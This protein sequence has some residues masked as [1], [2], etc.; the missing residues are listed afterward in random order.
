MEALERKNRR[1]KPAIIEALYRELGVCPGWIASGQGPIHTHDG[2]PYQI[3]EFLRWRDWRGQLEEPEEPAVTPAVGYQG[4]RL[5]PL[6]RKDCCPSASRALLYGPIEGSPE[7]TGSPRAY[8]KSMEMDRIRQYAAGFLDLA[9]GAVTQAL[10]NPKTA[11]I[12][13][14][15]AASKIRLVFPEA[16]PEK[17]ELYGDFWEVFTTSQAAPSLGSTRPEPPRQL[18]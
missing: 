7:G 13:L 5:G 3:K 8:Q 12:T 6:F 14:S 2:H 18:L 17:D 9:R 4:R 16:K 10:K 1:I 11:E 15:E